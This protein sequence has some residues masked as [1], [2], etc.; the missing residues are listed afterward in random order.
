MNEDNKI[1]EVMSLKQNNL[2]TSLALYNNI[3]K[4]KKSF[5]EK[6]KLDLRINAKNHSRNL[7]LRNMRV[8]NK[9][10]KFS[11]GNIKNI[12]IICFEFQDY[13]NKPSLGIRFSGKYRNS[14]YASEHKSRINR[15][16]NDNIQNKQFKSSNWWVAK[17]R[18]EP[19]NW[20]SSSTPWEMMKDD[21]MATKILDEVLEIYQILVQND[22][23][24]T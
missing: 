14:E 2:E 3:G 23:E 7:V 22:Y 5:V 1:V 8:D 20:S 18:F 24:I 15:L 16:L 6:L 17:D 4:M 12:G 9:Y 11:F 13:Y 19:F 10:E 21:T